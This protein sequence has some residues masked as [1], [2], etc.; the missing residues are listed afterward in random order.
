MRP[1][2]KDFFKFHPSTRQLFRNKLIP[3]NLMTLLLSMLTVDPSKRVQSVEE[4]LTFEFFSHCSDVQKD[5]EF[6]A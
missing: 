5:M 6:G 4:L 3:E 2:N 1:G